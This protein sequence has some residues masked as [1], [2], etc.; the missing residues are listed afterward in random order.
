MI[1]TAPGSAPPL[2]VH[3]EP[4]RAVAVFDASTFFQVSDPVL[5]SLTMAALRVASRDAGAIC[6]KAC[7]C[8]FSW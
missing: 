5:R 7:A 1:V 4:S 6:G 2:M 3:S 8:G